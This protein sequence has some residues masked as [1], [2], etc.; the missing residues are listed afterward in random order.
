MDHAEGFFPEREVLALRRQRLLSVEPAQ[1]ADA[2]RKAVWVALAV[3]FLCPIWVTGGGVELM[4]RPGIL[5]VACYLLAGFALA[6]IAIGLYRALLSGKRL[7]R[8]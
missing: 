1:P 2:R 7:A 5:L 4:K 6:G 3:C 8:V